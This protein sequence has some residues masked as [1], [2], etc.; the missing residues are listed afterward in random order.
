MSNTAVAVIVSQA[1]LGLLIIHLQQR[2]ARVEH[3]MRKMER[4]MDEMDTNIRA[5]WDSPTD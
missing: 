5:K 1:F 3:K 4:R 2:T